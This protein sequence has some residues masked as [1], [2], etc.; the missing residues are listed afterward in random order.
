MESF[1]GILLKFHDHENY[2]LNLSNGELWESVYYPPHDIDL[3]RQLIF[4]K[5]LLS[6]EEQIEHIKHLIGS[7]VGK[8]I[9]ISFIKFSIVA[10]KIRN[11][12]GSY[13]SSRQITTKS[14]ELNTKFTYER[15]NT[16]EEIFECFLHVL[17]IGKRYAALHNVEA[18]EKHEAQ[19]KQVKDEI[20]FMPPNGI[21][22][23]Q[24]R[25]EFNESAQFL[26]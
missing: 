16:K 26:H 1:Y 24:A 3:L 21:K 25:D 20:E 5:G 15:Q 7:N 11:E 19:T 12:S 9:T 8:S 14:T 13:A 23:Q 17:K 22:F 4:E 10:K 18:K 2:L 6:H